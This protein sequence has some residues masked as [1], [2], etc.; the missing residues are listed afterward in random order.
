MRIKYADHKTKQKK[1]QINWGLFALGATGVISYLWQKRK[2]EK[3]QVATLARAQ[4]TQSMH[5]ERTP[6]EPPSAKTAEARLAGMGINSDIPS[7]YQAS[8][9]NFKEI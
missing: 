8:G 5:Q 2:N 7:T 3:A 4:L 6:Q 1:I 9:E